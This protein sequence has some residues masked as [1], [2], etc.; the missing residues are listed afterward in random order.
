MNR[1]IPGYRPGATGGSVFSQ[2][3]LERRMTIIIIGFGLINTD[4][5]IT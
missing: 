5:S 1:V 4:G 3:W 2:E